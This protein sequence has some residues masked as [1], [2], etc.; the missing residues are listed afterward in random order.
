[1]VFTIETFILLPLLVL[2]F[3]FIIGSL[4]ILPIIILVNAKDYEEEEDNEINETKE[5]MPDLVSDCDKNENE[6]EYADMPDLVSDCDEN[7]NDTDE[8]I[9]SELLENKTVQSN[10]HVYI[11]IHIDNIECE[12]VSDCECELSKTNK[13]HV[14]I[15]EHDE[16]VL[17][18][19]NSKKD[20]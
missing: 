15:E 1:M 13:L 17:L 10:D 20:I 8:S 18:G 4:V 11:P 3:S 7:R 5:D 12:C 9:N 16:H 6:D 2:L 19:I 14:E